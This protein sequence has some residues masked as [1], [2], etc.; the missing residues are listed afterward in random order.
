MAESS[1]IS[2]KLSTT[3]SGWAGRRIK[4][5]TSSRTA[6][7]GPIWRTHYKWSSAGTYY[8]EKKS[9][10]SFRCSDKWE[11]G[12]C[13]LFGPTSP[14]PLHTK[15]CQKTRHGPPMLRWLQ[16]HKSFKLQIASLSLPLVG[17]LMTTSPRGHPC[18]PTE[19][20]ALQRC[21]LEL[22]FTALALWKPADPSDLICPGKHNCQQQGWT[23]QWVQHV[24]K[25]Q[26]MI[27]QHSHAFHCASALPN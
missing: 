8:R 24:S 7:N 14:L 15:T 11:E 2:A 16:A 4:P 1:A 20:A 5:V 22:Q 12:H 27:S 6:R 9:I 13:C 23:H 10:L 3:S 21:L 26:A 25:E 19:S 18:L 17:H